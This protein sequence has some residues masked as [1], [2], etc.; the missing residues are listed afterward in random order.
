L[1][2][3]F[4]KS[5]GIEVIEKFLDKFDGR[6]HLVMLYDDPVLA[7]RVE[8]L[9][10][11]K[12]LETEQGAFYVIPEDDVESPDS[13]RKQMEFFGFQTERLIRI[14][15]LR[16]ARISNPSNEPKGFRSG[17]EK[18]LKSLLRDQASTI[19]MVLQVRYLF[20]TGEEIRSHAEFESFI[21]SNFANFPGSML[22]NH[23]VGK[24]TVK[25]HGEWT[26]R[27]FTTHDWAFVVSSGESG[28][29]FGM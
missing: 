11:K 27:M 26:K 18:I 9:Y 8:F 14:G 28:L 24:N 12:G 23:Y 13:I 6:K 1:R 15:K 16:I 19:R 7:R 21:E 22:C 10:L 25:M 29:A 2:E 5:K 20:N 3:Q 17:C 4:T